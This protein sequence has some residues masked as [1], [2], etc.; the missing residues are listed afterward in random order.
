M[1]ILLVEE[2]K[3]IDKEVVQDAIKKWKDR[4]VNI[5]IKQF[6]LYRKFDEKKGWLLLLALEVESEDVLEIRE[7]MKLERKPKKLNIHVTLL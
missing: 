2:Q 6:H 5:T 4:P 3:S 1:S 7:D